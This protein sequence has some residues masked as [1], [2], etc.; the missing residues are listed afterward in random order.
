MPAEHRTVALE[1]IKNLVERAAEHVIEIVR[2]LNRT[3]DAVQRLEEPHVL[4]VLRLGA[5][6]LG[7]V[8][9]DAAVADKTPTS[10]NTG[11]PETDT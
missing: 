2:A 7:D 9:P 1:D 10:S 11:T 4:P 6:A 5:L 8:P 3:V